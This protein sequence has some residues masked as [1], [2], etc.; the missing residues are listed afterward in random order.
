[1]AG[2]TADFSHYARLNERSSLMD[3]IRKHFEFYGRVQGVGFRN[4]AYH[5]A[6]QFGVT[7]WVKNC[8]DGSVEM[9]AEGT[10]SDIDSLI[11]AVEKGTFVLI[12]NMSVKTIPIIGSRYFEI[13]D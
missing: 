4:R 8:S 3:K 2:G 6:R 11:L 13:I 7:G 10:E 1:M 12:E 5:A 9:E